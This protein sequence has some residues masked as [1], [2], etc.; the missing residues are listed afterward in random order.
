MLTRVSGRWESA[1][2]RG[3]LLQ[4]GWGAA[5]GY[6]GIVLDEHAE[7]VE[8]LVFSSEELALH[9]SRLDEFEG[10]GYERALVLAKLR[11]GTQ[12]DAYIYTLSNSDVPGNSS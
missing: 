11:D 9:W 6:L 12:V 8:G 2:V 3:R 7:E 5:I 1:T 4:Q 10:A